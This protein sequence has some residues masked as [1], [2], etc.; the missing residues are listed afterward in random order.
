[1]VAAVVVF[2]SAWWVAGRA[3][4]RADER[5]SDSDEGAGSATS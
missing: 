1:M 5:A 3:R 2:V 4:Q